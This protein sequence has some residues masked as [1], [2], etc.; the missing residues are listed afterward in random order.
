MNAPFL[1]A[2]LIYSYWT[3]TDCGQ[4]LLTCFQN[5]FFLL[6][7]ICQHTDLCLWSGVALFFPWN[8]LLVS[9]TWKICNSKTFQYTWHEKLISYWPESS[10]Q[11]SKERNNLSILVSV[12]VTALDT[13][14][15]VGRIGSWLCRVT[16]I[17]FKKKL[18]T[19]T[20]IR[21]FKI[22]S[23]TNVRVDDQQ[24]Q[25][26]WI[27][28]NSGNMTMM[29][30]FFVQYHIHIYHIG[31]E[32]N[33]DFCFKRR[34][35]IVLTCWLVQFFLAITWCYVIVEVLPIIKDKKH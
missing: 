31:F 12:I 1:V 29:E 4:N 5:A 11:G 28:S 14:K 3:V 23:E 19:Q 32:L 10:P 35:N 9:R 33:L 2:L 24:P 27:S 8:V 30:M 17:H 20:N 15:I 6:T 16:E 34:P 7:T 25:H 26:A 21:N 13:D 18:I 22:N